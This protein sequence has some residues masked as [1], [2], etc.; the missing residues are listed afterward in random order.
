MSNEALEIERIHVFAQGETPSTIKSIK[1]KDIENTI[2]INE[3]IDGLKAKTLDIQGVS[4]LDETFV[5]QPDLYRELS[6]NYVFEQNFIVDCLFYYTD[7]YQKGY[8]SMHAGIS[9][10]ETYANFKAEN[11]YVVPVK[12][13]A[14]CEV[15]GMEELMCNIDKGPAIETLDLTHLDTTNVTSMY[16]MFCNLYDVTHIKFGAKFNTTNVLTM[17]G[18]FKNCVALKELNLKGF[19]TLKVTSMKEMFYSCKSL[20]T[21]PLRDFFVENVTDMCRMFMKCVKLE[22]LQIDTWDITKVIDFED[23]TKGT[24]NL[25]VF[26]VPFNMTQKQIQKFCKSTFELRENFHD[27]FNF[28]AFLE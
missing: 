25:Q 9:F 19:N 13:V 3:V 18:M 7:H 26:Q 11:I 27:K 15:I 20:K 2:S 1:M 4:L 10:R 22:V 23:F 21:L 16:E 24:Y 6:L 8:K 5:I 14:G 28:L 17:S 12:Y